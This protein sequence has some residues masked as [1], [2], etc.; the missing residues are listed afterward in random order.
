[1]VRAMSGPATDPDDVLERS[2]D[3]AAD[4]YE[5]YFVPRFAPWVAAATQPVAAAALADGPILVPCCGP[6]PELDGLIERFPDRDIVGLDLS[7]GMLQL[8]QARAAGRP[9]VQLV[10]GDAA[11]LDPAWTA[12]CAAVVSVFGLQQLPQPEAAL[13]SW[14]GALRPG[15]ML[16]VM[17]WPEVTETDGPFA[18]VDEVQ[19]EPAPDPDA[20]PDPRFGPALT[21]SG[22]TVLRD[23]A[24]AF[25]ISHPSAAAYFDA[26]TGSGP[27][28]SL[29][30]T[31]GPTHIAQLREQ[32]LRRA[33][34]GEWTHRPRA[35]HLVAR[36][37]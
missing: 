17:F 9:R 23:E 22:A 36:R 31:K 13:R 14:V 15:G 28:R 32:F 24:C 6:F 30:L 35:W 25:S 29:A 19:G 37:D 33:P 3:E 26:L 5:A 2:W 10:H 4:G 34:A 20:M 8:A 12:Q 18:L 7:A 16:S 1:M 27:L 11:T 21:A